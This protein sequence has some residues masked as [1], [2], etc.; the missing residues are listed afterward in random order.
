[1][2]LVN[3]TKRVQGGMDSPDKEVHVWMD[4]P[5]KG[6]KKGWTDLISRYRFFSGEAGPK[7]THWTSVL[8]RHLFHMLFL[9]STE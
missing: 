4:L 5:G 9:L 8:Y 1:M 2:G 7:S 3:I 6:L